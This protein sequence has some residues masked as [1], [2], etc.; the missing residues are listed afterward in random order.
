MS[1]SEATMVTKVHGEKAAVRRALG[2]V[3]FCEVAR[4]HRSDPIWQM[5]T[6]V[7]LTPGRDE[8]GWL[9]ALQRRC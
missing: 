9:S 2:N 7:T 3:G 5:R 8:H 4:M 1:T 6:R